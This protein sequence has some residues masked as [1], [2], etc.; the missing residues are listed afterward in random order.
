LQLHSSPHSRE[1]DNRIGAREFIGVEFPTPLCITGENRFRIQVA[2][3]KNSNIWVASSAAAFKDK[4]NLYG[5][6]LQVASK[7]PHK[8]SHEQKAREPEGAHVH[9]ERSA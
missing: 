8:G 7:Y 4:L 6:C 5:S 3:T 2:L 1:S 9:V